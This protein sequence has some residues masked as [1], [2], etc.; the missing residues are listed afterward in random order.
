[1]SVVIAE[2]QTKNELVYPFKKYWSPEPG[3]L[4]EVA[5]GVYWLRMPLPIALD[6]IN[7]WL[8]QDG[9]DWVIVDTGYDAK[10]CKAVWQAVFDD[11]VDPK[12]VSRI[13]V[14]HF[15]PDHIGLA[16]WLSQ[17]CD[18]RIYITQ[19]ELD[20]YRK[21]HSRQQSRV[22]DMVQAYL[23]ELGFDAATTE[24]YLPFFLSDPKPTTD[25]VQPEQCEILREQDELRIN[26]QLWRVVC[27]NGHSPEHACLYNANQ[28]LLIAGDQAIPRISSNVSVYPANRHADPLGDWIASCEKLRDVIPADTVILP[29]HQEPFVG[30]QT[31]MQQL[32]DDHHRQLNQLR[33][34]VQAP[35]ST[36]QA[37]DILFTR[38][39]NVVDT[40]LATGETLAHLN[41]LLHRREIAAKPDA[42]GVTLYYQRR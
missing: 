14:T 24:T 34:A 9:D 32:I 11:V 2:S 31:R 10:I 23:T 4:F 20:L 16:A 15:H 13:I 37:R 36:V 26:G 5:Q 40:L 1:M 7:L 39:L 25:R 41:Y 21:I 29:S 19:G 8:L 33:L 42:N 18:S 30:I 6:H 12:R 27:G 3:A 22:R 38:E 35:I 17:R 28:K